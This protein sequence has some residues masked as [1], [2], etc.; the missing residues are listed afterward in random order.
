MVS[1]WRQTVQQL[2]ATIAHYTGILDAF[3]IARARSGQYVRAINYHWTPTADALQLEKQ[4]RYFASCFQSLDATLLRQFLNGHIQL[5]KPGIMICFDDGFRNNFE[6]AAPLLEKFGLTG[7]FFIVA[8]ACDQATK[9][10]NG[11]LNTNYCMK[12]PE[13][14]D[15]VARGHEIGCHTFTHA[16]LGPESRFDLQEEVVRSRRVLSETLGIAID[17]F[18]F[19]YG[20]AECYSKVSLTEVSKHYEFAFHNFPSAISPGNHPLSLGRIPFEPQWSIE[21]AKFRIS[22]LMDMRYARQLRKYLLALEEI[23]T[24]TTSTV[25]G[26]RNES[27]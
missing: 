13:L 18:C 26:D 20:G 6:V 1:P 22:G 15:L 3:Q 25:V 23:D 27:T 11:T 2:A 5:E 10:F 4:F 8:G 9:V 7:W 17:S 24:N 21:V 19:T 12:W 14:R 16:H